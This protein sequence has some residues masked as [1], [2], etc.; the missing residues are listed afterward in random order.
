MRNIGILFISLVIMTS[1]LND[2][3]EVE[4]K[5]DITTLNFWKTPG[6]ARS[7][8]NAAYAELQISLGDNGGLNYAF[9][10]EARSDNFIGKTEL[11]AYPFGTINFNIL[12]STHPSANWNRYYR[13]ISIANYALHYVPQMTNIPEIQRENFLAEAYFL[14]AYSYFLLVRLWGDVP[15]VT[16]PVLTIT[17][18]TK[19][20][21]APK[22]SILKLIGSDLELSVEKTD[23]TINNVYLCNAGAIY[24][25]Y[26]DYALWIKDYEKAVLYSQ[27]LYDLKRYNLVPG[28]D[29]ST[30]FTNG[31]TTENIWTLKWNYAN[32][33]YNRGIYTMNPQGLAYIITSEPVR[34][35]WAKPQWRADKRRYQTID[36]TYNYVL[37]HIDNPDS[38]GAIWKWAPNVRLNQTTEAPVPLYRLADIIL[39]RAEALNKQGKTADA[40]AELNKVRDR[41]GLA[42]RTIDEFSSLSDQ[43]RMDSVENIILQERQFELLGEGKRWFDLVRTD[44]AMNTMNSFFSNYIEKK[45][46]QKPN[47]FKEEWQLYWPVYFNNI[48]ENENLTQTGGY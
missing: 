19:P 29:F 37:G 16:E 4:P 47:H 39:L 33:G 7:A 41:A 21:K 9:L 30:L 24:A 32:N 14:R 40:L 35:L 45:S 36:T 25:L 18:I 1:C 5:T 20:A 43:H 13:M 26:T 10:F 17:D 27:K 6:D 42:V 31:T 23:E 3:L 38:R 11:M 28:T 44:K 46:F 22:D 2:F 34:Q 12:T 8:L 15:M 48:Q